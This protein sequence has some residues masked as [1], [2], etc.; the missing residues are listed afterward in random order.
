MLRVLYEEP[1]PAQAQYFCH[2][3]YVS[4]LHSFT[5]PSQ[6]ESSHWELCKDSAPGTSVAECVPKTWMS[7]TRPRCC[8]IAKG[9]SLPKRFGLL[10]FIPCGFLATPPPKKIQFRAIRRVPITVCQPSR[11]KLHDN[12]QSP[13]GTPTVPHSRQQHPLSTAATPR[14]A[15]AAGPP[16]EPLSTMG[17]LTS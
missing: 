8:F 9:F 4:S 6:V 14:P 7:I 1:Q 13:H 12:A 11:A 16:T 2:Y 5:V 17:S 3:I 15:P 10:E